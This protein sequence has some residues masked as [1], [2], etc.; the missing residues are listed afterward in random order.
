MG[1]DGA[2]LKLPPLLVR[3]LGSCRTRC[4]VGGRRWWCVGPAL[5][6]MRA[7]ALLFAG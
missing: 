5:P 1:G 3:V 4:G 2:E 7:G 6:D